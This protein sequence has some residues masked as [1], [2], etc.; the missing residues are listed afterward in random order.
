LTIGEQIKRFRK[1]KGLT[2]K[3][4]GELSKTS[5]GTVRQYELGKRQPRL[6]Q[7]KKIATA[8]NVSVNSLIASEPGIL[9]PLLPPGLQGTDFNETTVD[10]DMLCYMLDILEQTD[11]L[12]R[13]YPDLYQRLKEALY[14]LAVSSGLEHIL[15]YYWGSVYDDDEIDLSTP[16]SQAVIQKIRSDM[17][18]A[19]QLKKLTTSEAHRAGFLQFK[20]E[21]DRIAFFY[22]RLNTDGKLAASKCFYQHLDKG[23][24]GEVADF[25]EK[26]SEIP[27]YQRT[28]TPQ[29]PVAAPEGTDT[30]PPQNQPETPPEGE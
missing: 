8:L 9:D 13:T 3:Q 26:L 12:E 24:I 15:V 27:Q 11:D 21:E 19:P 18:K 14:A 2:Q 1:E 6:A 30:T 17:Q 7:L 25:I 22:S 5:E 28:A 20:S 29:P 10:E 16:E 23:N 4:L